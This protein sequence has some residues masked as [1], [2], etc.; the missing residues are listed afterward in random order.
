M[1]AK[2]LVGLAILVVV[3]IVVIILPPSDFRITRTAAIAA[4]PSVV[5]AQV[6]DLHKYQAWSPFAKA[7]PAMKITY[8][9]PPTGEGAVLA[10]AGNNKTGEGRMTL[11]ESR[12]NELVR[13]NLQFIKPFQATNVAE[14]TFKPEGNQTVVTW[15][16]TG[17]NNFMFKAVGL[18]MNS[19]KMVG[20]MFEEGLANLKAKS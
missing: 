12:P 11:T 19:D 15:S 20:G 8:E 14:F 3:L 4:P 7:D 18:F 5:F 17:K 1:I 16:M 6:N 13:S 2:I 9:G 10:W